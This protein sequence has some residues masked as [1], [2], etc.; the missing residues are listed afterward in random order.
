MSDIEAQISV[1]KQSADPAVADA[2]G[3]LIKDLKAL[4]GE[5]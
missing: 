5:T 2:I 3:E 1:L 4:R